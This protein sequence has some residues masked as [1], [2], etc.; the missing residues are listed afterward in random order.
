VSRYTPNVAAGEVGVRRQGLILPGA[1]A[2]GTTRYL[3][4][5][6]VSYYLLEDDSSF[7]VQE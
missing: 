6:G 3:L 4:E 5:D 2:A 1:A 7:F